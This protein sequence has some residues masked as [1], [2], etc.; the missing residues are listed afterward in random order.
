MASRSVKRRG[1]RYSVCQLACGAL[2]PS[3]V[4]VFEGNVG[5]IGTRWL[6]E[7]RLEEASC[8]RG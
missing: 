1:Q 2:N 8:R 6:E 4:D 5:E 7:G 3:T